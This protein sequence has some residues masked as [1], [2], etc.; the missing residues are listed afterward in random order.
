ML[1]LFTSVIIDLKGYM[2][3]IFILFGFFLIL[4]V[5]GVFVALFINPQLFRDQ[6]DVQLRDGVSTSGSSAPIYEY[7][8]KVQLN[9][10]DANDRLGN[11]VDLDNGYAIVGAHLEGSDVVDNV[12][13]AYIFHRDSTEWQQQVRIDSGGQE[14][15]FFGHSVSIDGG[16]AVVGAYGVDSGGI[17]DTGAAYIFRRDGTEWQQQA[18]IQADDA[19]EGDWFG[20]S[21]AIDGDYVVVGV[22]R[23]DLGGITDAGAAYIFRRDGTEWQ[24]QAKIQADDAQ[25]GDWFGYSVAIDGDYVVVGAHEEDSNNVNSSG[26]AYVFARDEVGW[27]QEAKINPHD[28]DIGEGENFGKSVAIDA[29]YVAVGAYR[30]GGDQG[31]V[32]IFHYDTDT[33]SWDLAQKIQAD[34]ERGAHFGY[35][36]AL[37]GDTL[38][39]G[40]PQENVD[41]GFVYI[42][43]RNSQFGS[44]W[45]SVGRVQPNDVREGDEFGRSVAVDSGETIIVGAWLEEYDSAKEDTG[46]AYIFRLIGQ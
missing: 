44:Q 38:I 33:E 21:V 1:V 23:K 10:S 14:N 17:V 8:R 45:L 4:V 2:N 39:A 22:H 11:S 9:D 15:E 24:Q 46:S 3:K 30:E 20:Y 7:F 42:F 13:A 18:K 43:K 16:Y 35:S 36:V 5:I 34:N 6:S 29:N 41:S 31:A 32:Y 25:E 12:G 19:Q 28:A 26:S 40:A 27:S 37:S